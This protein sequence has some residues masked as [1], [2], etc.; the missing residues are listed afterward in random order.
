MPQVYDIETEE[1]IDEA[2]YERRLRERARRAGQ[3]TYTQHPLRQPVEVPPEEPQQEEPEQSYDQPAEE[4][5]TLHPGFGPPTQ[6]DTS[7][8]ALRERQYAER[9]EQAMPPQLPRIFAGGVEQNERPVPMS[10]FTP[11]GT[12]SLGGQTGKIND[13]R[14]R[15]PLYRSPYPDSSQIPP[16]PP[17]PEARLA[18]TLAQLGAATPSQAE[19]LQGARLQQA[20]AAIDTHVANATIDAGVGMQ[21]RQM[22]QQQL[23]PLMVRRSQIPMYVARA[24]YQQ[25]MLQNSQRSAIMQ[26]NAEFRARTAQQRV[27]TVT[28]ENGQMM[29][30]VEQPNGTLLPLRDVAGNE[31]QQQQRQQLTDFRREQSRWDRLSQQVRSEVMAQFRR[32]ERAATDAGTPFPRADRLMAAENEIRLQTEARYGGQRPQPPTAGGQQPQGGGQPAPQGQPPAQNGQQPS[33]PSGG[34]NGRLSQQEFQTLVQ[35]LLSQAA[36][37]RRAERR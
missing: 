4:P 19:N 12:N 1:T 34:G 23:Q 30:F 27:H 3:Q 16:P 24:R 6:A 28:D 20:L 13:P 35:Q 8:Q 36:T 11:S 29:R 10:A 22:I 2:E 18:Q 14:F 26:Q 17:P 5:W 33:A 32:D 9:E 21:A 25:M 37:P 31:Q 15:S 7:R